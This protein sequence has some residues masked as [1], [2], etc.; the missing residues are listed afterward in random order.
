MTD[1]VLDSVCVTRDGRNVLDNVTTQFGSNELV[2]LLGANGAGKSTLIRSGLGLIPVQQGTAHIDGQDSNRINPADRARK[3]A[4]LPQ[5]RSLSWPLNVLDTI[6]LGRYAY[7]VRLGRLSSTDNDAVQRAVRACDLEHLVHRRVDQ[8]SGGELARV[9]CAR[10]FAG[11]APMLLADEPVAELDPLH[12]FQLM[13][14]IRDYVDDDNGAVV[15][16]HDPELAARFADRLVW[17][18]GGKIVADG[19]VMGTL[20]SEQLASVY[21]MRADVFWRDKEAQVTMIGPVSHANE[22]S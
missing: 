6:A 19:T 2:A 3:V 22:K 8:L 5:S 18:V 4:Y 11:E 12:Q 14:L 20:T 10:A 1:I 21:G 9:H 13:Q 17:M 16:M 7:G 15:I